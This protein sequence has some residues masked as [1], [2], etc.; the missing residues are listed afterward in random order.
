MLCPKCGARSKCV[1]TSRDFSD[2]IRR[3]RRCPRCDHQ[4]VTAQ[5]FE[6]I[7]QVQKEPYT[8]VFSKQDIFR[9]R[10][11]W[12]NEGKSIPEVAEIFGCSKSWANKIVT[13]KAWKRLL[14]TEQNTKSHPLFEWLLNWAISSNITQKN[15]NRRPPLIFW[16]HRCPLLF[17]KTIRAGLLYIEANLNRRHQQ[18]NRLEPRGFN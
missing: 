10:E 18:S 15:R 7:I 14:P 12:F 6:Q 11:M 8:Q 1:T 17:Y 4:F 16:N 3:Y 2:H 13:G 5:P 9:M